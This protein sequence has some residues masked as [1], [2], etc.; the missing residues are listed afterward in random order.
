ML[1]GDITLDKME[2]ILVTNPLTAAMFTSVNGRD[3][4]YHLNTGG[5]TKMV[6]FKRK[7]ADDASDDTTLLTYGNAD[8]KALLSAAQIKKDERRPHQT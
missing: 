3:G 4:V 7:A 8:L 2:L 6:T 1:V 5:E